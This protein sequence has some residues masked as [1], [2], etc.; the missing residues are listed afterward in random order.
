MEILSVGVAKGDES[1]KKKDVVEKLYRA[2]VKG[3]KMSQKN[4]HI[5][6]LEAI[7]AIKTTNKMIL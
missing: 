7:K 2:S 5:L 4:P 3:I 6:K 1:F